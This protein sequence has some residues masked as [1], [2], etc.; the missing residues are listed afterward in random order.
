LEIEPETG[1]AASRPT[2]SQLDRDATMYIK[3]ENDRQ[4]ER[5]A[6]LAKEIWINHFGRM[7]TREILDVIIETIQSKEAI[8]KQ[9]DDGLLYYLI[10]GRRAPVGYFAYCLSEPESELFLSKLYILAAER[11]KGIGRQV[12]RHLET[13]CCNEALST[14][15][16]T[17]YHKNT[18]AIEA[19][20]KMGFIATGTIHRDL[21]NGITFDDILMQK[22]I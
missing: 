21:G 4:V 16:L 2:V 13:I 12:I 15:R 17:V 7:F 5:L 9:M 1:A 14:I 22:T 11:R 8:A 3:V 20:K 18:D 19:Y 10:P 6:Y